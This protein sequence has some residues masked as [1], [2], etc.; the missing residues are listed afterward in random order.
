MDGGC[1]TIWRK[2][3]LSIAEKNRIKKYSVGINRR[4]SAFSI[5]IEKPEQ[6]KPNKKEQL[7]K[8]F[9]GLPEEEITLYGFADFIFIAAEEIL[10]NF[11]GYLEI[12]LGESKEVI[13]EVEGE[14]I[15]L[16]E[17]KNGLTPYESPGLL[18]VDYLFVMNYFN[19]NS[20]SKI[21]DICNL[22]TYL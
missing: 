1:I 15:E 21:Q 22:D 6:I 17:R 20:N 5:Q 14:A 16:V 10:K 18:L 13:L 12:S 3:P 2:E 8:V 11:G 19:G 4:A 9:N 7:I